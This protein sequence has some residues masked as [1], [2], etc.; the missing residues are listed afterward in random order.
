MARTAPA[1]RG[2]PG[3]LLAAALLPGAARAAAV[4]DAAEAALG[5]FVPFAV[6]ALLVGAEVFRRKLGVG[7]ARALGWSALANLASVPVAFAAAYALMLALFPRDAHFISV[8]A[9]LL[10]AYFL[11]W[12]V[13]WPVVAALA[14]GRTE[15]GKI[16]PR[17][18]TLAAN[19]ICLLL[20]AALAIAAYPAPGK[21]PR[22]RVA[23]ALEEMAAIEREVTASA[24]SGKGLPAPR[25]VPVA[26]EGALQSLKIGKEGRIEGALRIEREREL[27]GKAIVMEPRLGQGRVD[28]WICHTDAGLPGQQYLPSRCRQSREG[29]EQAERSGLRVGEP[30]S[31]S[32]R[33]R[34]VP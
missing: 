34:S 24:A 3:A 1:F 8:T 31:A 6:F 32:P 22:Q 14:R 12:L 16:P 29:V 5:I 23:A 30:A 25:P 11:S 9:G 7:T 10:L 19:G 15:A 4:H 18:A 21:A 28:R 20:A 27:H 17:A 13:Q 26:P 33:G 2:T